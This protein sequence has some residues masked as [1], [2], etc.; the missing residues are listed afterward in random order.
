MNNLEKFLYTPFGNNIII[1]S[2][3]KDQLTFLKKILP[4]DF[5]KR[6]MY[7]L[8]CGDGKV[9]I[10][11]TEIFQPKK[12]FACDIEESLIKKARKRGINAKVMNLEEEMPN[13][14]LAVMWGVLH[15][16]KNPKEVL[17]RIKNNFQYFFLREPLKKEGDNSKLN[18]S[19]ILELGKPFRKEE[20]KKILDEIFENCEIFE[21]NGAIMMLWEKEE[22]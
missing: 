18:I 17:K 12:V 6:E 19:N 4:E 22:F 5:R 21:Y 8:G 1:G 3:I 13:G 9:T 2:H 14:E 16:L 11:L 15:H 10:L 7:D 20:I